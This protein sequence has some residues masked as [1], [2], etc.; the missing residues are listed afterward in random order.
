V[1]STAEPSA[2][3]GGRETVLVA[4]D[5]DAVREVT[6]ELL[7]ALGYTV[8]TA[9]RGEQALELA[10]AHPGPIDL[11]LTDVVMP[12]LRGAS[13]AEQL[14]ASRPGVR[15][16]FMSGYGDGVAPEGAGE[17]DVVLRKPFDQDR[18]A[19]AV[20]EALDRGRA[21]RG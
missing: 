2:L 3:P 8:M 11:L 13:L 10:R 15:V 16:L 21:P 1:R 18:L 17:R 7:E 19:L 14:V 12:G 5:S 4:E 9:A 20:R 6:R